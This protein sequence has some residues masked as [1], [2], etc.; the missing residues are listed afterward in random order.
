[1]HVETAL[2]NGEPLHQIEQ[3]LDQ[4]ENDPIREAVDA[5]QPQVDVVDC[6]A[7]AVGRVMDEATVDWNTRRLVASCLS[8][9]REQ[10]TLLRRQLQ[11]ADD[12]I[13]IM[14]ERLRFHE[15]SRTESDLVRGLNLVDAALPNGV[16]CHDPR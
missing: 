6:L 8:H 13:A 12:T 1:M 9:T 3:T 2:N 15:A 14:G 16:G 10:V 5:G 11:V 4:A 7:D